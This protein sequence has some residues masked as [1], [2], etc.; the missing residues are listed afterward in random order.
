MTEAT[1]TAQFP[2][3]KSTGRYRWIV[4]ALLFTAIVINYI[5]RQMLG[6]L[7]PVLSTEMGWSESDYA[8]IVFWFQAA[9]AIAY[10][11][12][13][14]FIDRIGARW[15]YAIAFSIWQLAHIAHAGAR[16]IGH[17]IFARVALGIGEAGSFPASLKAVTEWFPKKERAFATGLFNAGSNI[18]AILT[19]LIIPTITLAWGWQMAFIVT[20]LGSF[21][22]LAIWLL[23][24]RAPRRHKRVSEGELAYIEQDPADPDVGKRTG[25][26]VLLRRRETWAFALGKFLIDPVWWMFLFWLPDFFFKTY[27]LNL[28]SFG[29][30]LVVVYILS[31]IGSIA[32]GWFSSRLI[33]SGKSINFS[34]KTA[35]FVCG[36][37]A[38]PVI[39]ASNVSNLWLAVL[40]VGIATAAHQGFSANLLTLPGDVLP[41]RAVGSVIG[42]GGMFGAIGGMAMAK[43]AGYVLE[44]IGTY[45][46][47]FFVAG[48][49]YL[50]A[51]VVI[52]LLTPR[53]EPVKV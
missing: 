17:F 38:L 3:L 31:D 25:W 23:V 50:L 6:I 19:P 20:G 21:I 46:P 8:N 37:L 9:Y 43:Y 45:Q 7:K 1:S 4:C 39:F 27:N 15:G 24:Y 34:R 48:F 44:K 42:I 13:G 36:L 49:A 12:F 52:H 30:P 10:V 22:W 16:E 41:R 33:H 29:P 40:I 51:L 47:I 14:R 32:G 53:M 28:K 18:G 11:V 26:G 2:P 35:M 5:D